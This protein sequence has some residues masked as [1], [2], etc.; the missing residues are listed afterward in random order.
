LLKVEARN[1][2]F[3]SE[4]RLSRENYRKVKSDYSEAEAWAKCAVRGGGTQKVG[5]VPVFGVGWI[6][7]F[8]QH[9]G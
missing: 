6:V 2:V 3:K 4:R 5:C 1:N 7:R 8:R 9:I